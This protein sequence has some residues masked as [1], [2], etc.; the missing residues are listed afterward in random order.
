M[1]AEGIQIESHINFCIAA[2]VEETLRT[3]DQQMSEELDLD[4]FEA[5]TGHSASITNTTEIIIITTSTDEKHTESNRPQTNTS[6]RQMVRVAY[7]QNKI[8]GILSEYE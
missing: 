2:S 7:K 5:G 4:E 3:S 6:L 1:S 8:L